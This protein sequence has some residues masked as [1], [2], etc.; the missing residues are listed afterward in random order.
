MVISRVAEH[1]ADCRKARGGEGEN[2]NADGAADKAGQIR[3]HQR[4]TGTAL[5]RHG[6]AVQ[7]GGDGRGVA[8]D[9]QQDR[10]E[11][12]AVHIGV[13]ERAQ[14]DDGGGGVEFVGQGQ[15]QRAASQRTDARHSADHQSQNRAQKTDPDVLRRQCYLEARKQRCK[16]FH[17]SNGPP[18]QNHF[19]Q[20]THGETDLQPEGKHAQDN[21]GHNQLND[22]ND[23]P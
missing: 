4:L 23:F 18:L 6:I 21:R 17:T 7:R 10:A 15:E 12:T 2:Q 8:G 20:H 14:H 16:I 5:P 1:Q 3:S 22:D 19:Q 9:V 13:V 11:G